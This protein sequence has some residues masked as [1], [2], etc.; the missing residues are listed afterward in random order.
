MVRAATMVNHLVRHVQSGSLARLIQQHFGRITSL[1]AVCCIILLQ[2]PNSTNR[3]FWNRSSKKIRAIVVE[4]FLANNSSAVAD[5]EIRIRQSHLEK[6]KGLSQKFAEAQWNGQ[7]SFGRVGDFEKIA[8]WASN[9]VLYIL[10]SESWS[11]K[12]ELLFVSG[13]G[14]GFH[15]K[16]ILFVSLGFCELLRG[17]LRNL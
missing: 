10:W 12:C 1:H 14:R 5:G 3:I 7:N 6:H 11:L 17:P 15:V 13:G 16:L 2:E 9:G 8:L 4:T